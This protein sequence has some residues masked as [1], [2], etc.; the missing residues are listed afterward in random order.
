MEKSKLKWG[1]SEKITIVNVC[2]CFCF[3]QYKCM[4]FTTNLG[5]SQSLSPG[6]SN[7][8]S[9][10]VEQRVSVK[11]TYDAYKCVFICAYACDINHAYDLQKS[12]NIPGCY[13]TDVF[14]DTKVLLVYECKTLKD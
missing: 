10:S 5:T 6:G 9:C 8:D 4:S 1:K 2:F 7:N 14:I 12:L 11:N 13:I 3:R